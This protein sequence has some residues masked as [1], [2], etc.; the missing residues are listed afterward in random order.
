MRLQSISYTNAVANFMNKHS[1]PMRE[2]ITIPTMNELKL[3]RRLIE[4][5]CLET[6]K[7]IDECV[8][9]RNSE[10]L[11]V[12]G[13]VVTSA[14]IEVADGLADQL[15]VIFGTALAFGIPIESVFAEVHRSNMTKPIKKLG[16]TNDGTKV[17][18]GN[19]SRPQ[20][21]AILEMFR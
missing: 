9:L 2:K 18:K 16:H 8:L 20:I 10:A 4:E 14:L 19:Y 21:G 3:R 15:Y 1:Q 13:Q 7:A 5:E 12:N 17:E 11:I 6:L